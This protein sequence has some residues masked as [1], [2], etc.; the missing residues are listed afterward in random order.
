MTI[1]RPVNRRSERIPA[2]GL[3]ADA[4]FPDVFVPVHTAAARLLRVVGVE[5]LQPID[6]EGVRSNASNVSVMAPAGD[7]QVVTGGDEMARIEAHADPWAMAVDVLEDGCEVLEAVP[8][9]APLAGRVL[10]QHHRKGYASAQSAKGR[11]D[12]VG[13]EPQPVL[14]A[15]GLDTC[16]GE[17]TTPRSP[18]ASAR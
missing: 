4:P 15:A 14:F 6:P 11:S 3:E 1:G 2:E 18:S 16:P 5:D 7:G 17:R 8:E 13:N 10:E 12:R 9:R